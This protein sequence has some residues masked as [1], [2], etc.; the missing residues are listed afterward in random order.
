MSFPSFLWDCFI[1]FYLCHILSY[2]NFLL[3]FPV[4]LRR[5]VQILPLLITVC[6]L[7][8][9]FP[10][11]TPSAFGTS[12]FSNYLSLSVFIH[13][14]LE[15]KNTKVHFKVRPWFIIVSKFT[16][17]LSYSRSVSLFFCRWCLAAPGEHP[18]LR[19]SFRSTGQ[20]H[21]HPLLGIS[22]IHACLLL[23]PL[24]LPC[25]TSGQVDCGVRWGGDAD[26]G[27]AG[28]K[29]EGKQSVQRPRCLA[30]LYF[31]PWWS[32]TVV[33]RFTLQRLGSLSLW[34]AAGPGGCQRSRT[35]QGQR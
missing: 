11:Q 19:S 25:C 29:S 21:L 33:G 1:D 27:G 32:V 35:T 8:L 13:I 24:F 23:L 9:G 3:C 2:L 12:T 7:T 6:R 5:H 22:L 31:L 14:Q 18:P 20:L 10:T 17:P 26:L 28:S 4:Y 16:E 15:A 30:Q 34:G